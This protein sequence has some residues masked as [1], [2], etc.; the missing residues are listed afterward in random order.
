LLLLC[1]ACST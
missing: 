1:Q